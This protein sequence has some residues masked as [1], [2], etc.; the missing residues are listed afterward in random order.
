MKPAFALVALVLLFSIPAHAQAAGGAASPPRASG[1]GAAGGGASSGS[2]GTRPSYTPTAQF[3][4]AAVSGSS[5]DFIPSAYL[6]FDKAVALGQTNSS[7]KPETIVEVA[8]AYRNAKGQ[9]PEHVIIQDLR[10]NFV[11]DSK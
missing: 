9:N 1:G 6:P 11:Q 4:M 2:A 7:A 10:G 5:T 8:Q 3:K